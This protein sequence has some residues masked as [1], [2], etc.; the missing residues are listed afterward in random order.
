MPKYT[1][2]ACANMRVQYNYSADYR[3]A[4]VL[5]SREWRHIRLY[6]HLRRGDYSE[7]TKVLYLSVRVFST[8][9]LIVDTVNKQT[10]IANRT[11]INN[12]NWWEADQ[13]AIYEA[14]RS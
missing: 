3:N 9:V 4:C 6:N 1:R 2:S 8:V 10:N 5:I 11:E 12:P 7:S 13:L 14:W